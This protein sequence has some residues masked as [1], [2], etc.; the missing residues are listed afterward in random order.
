ML[1]AML[2]ITGLACIAETYPMVY[3]I[4]CLGLIF[5]IA[6]NAG[7]HGSKEN[8]IHRMEQKHAKR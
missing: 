7:T 1:S 2:F 6:E 3:V 4:L 8:R 5:Y